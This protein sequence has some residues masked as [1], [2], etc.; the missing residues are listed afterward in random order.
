MLGPV[1][2]FQQHSIDPH[3]EGK[4][5]SRPINFLKVEKTGG[6]VYGLAKYCE[7]PVE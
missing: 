6:K 2:K 5:T 1:D 3:F 7:S 4:N